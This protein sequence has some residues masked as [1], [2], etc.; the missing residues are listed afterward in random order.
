[1]TDERTSMPQASRPVE[2][3]F[4]ELDRRRSLDP[5]VHS[6]RLFGLVYPTNR[7]DIE[8][9]VRAV[10]DRFIFTNA[11]NPLRFVEV[12]AME[13]DVVQM[14]EGLV[15]RPSTGHHGGSVTSGGTESILMSMLVSRERA[16]ARGVTRPAILAPE[17]AHPAYAKAAHYF[18]MDY[19]RIPLDAR[20]RADV[21]RARELV[22]EDTAV[23][24]A[25]AYSYPHGAMD[26]VEELAALAV[27]GG[28]GCHV[29]ACIGG[30]VLPFME[31]LGEAVPP[32]DFRVEGVTQISM[33]AHKYGYVP[34]GVSVVLHRDDD[35]LWLQTFFY[36]QWGS[37]LY[38]TAGISGARPAAPV[39]AAWAMM[40]HLGIDGYCGLVRELL[41]ITRRMRAGIEEIAGLEIVGDP[42]GPLLAVRSDSHDLYA[43]ADAMDHKGWHLNR[44]TDPVG[45]HMMLSP[46]HADIADEF[47]A[48][49]ADAVANHGPSQGTPA[50]YA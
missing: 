18:D 15:H 45:L 24:V 43:I 23:I 40:Q 39:I 37:G 34:K 22:T 25:S 3:V 31:M 19:V 28:F 38:A 46:I 4:D 42:V 13:R 16:R 5:D 29:D 36:E 9:V 20:Y 41:D 44:N 10:Y 47:L 1:V 48:D 12:A 8:D 32:W 49:L 14:T 26:P 11:L 2:D 33:D 21:E 6:G 50:R 30:F 35:S 7:Q 17:S 27:A